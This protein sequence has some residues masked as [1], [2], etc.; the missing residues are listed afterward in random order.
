MSEEQKRDVVVNVNTDANIDV[1]ANAAY[2]RVVTKSHFPFCG[3]KAGTTFIK[4]LT[5]R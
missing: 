1:D 4:S 5:A 2:F 3:S